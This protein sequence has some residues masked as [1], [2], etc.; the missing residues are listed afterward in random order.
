MILARLQVDG[1]AIHQL[2]HAEIGRLIIGPPGL[3]TLWRFPF[4]RCTHRSHE[5]TR[6]FAAVA[7]CHG[8]KVVLFILNQTF[9]SRK[10]ARQRTWS[11]GEKWQ[12]HRQAK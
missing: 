6:A 3:L 8:R 9:S 2:E 5:F 11:S 1:V 10:Q 4:L 7:G 12:A